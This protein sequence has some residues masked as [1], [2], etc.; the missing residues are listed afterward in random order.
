[1]RFIFEG[2]LPPYLMAKDLILT[3][4]GDVGFEGGTYRALQFTGSAVY[5]LS[6]EERMTLTN[7]AIEAGAKNGIIEA[8]DKTIDYVSERTDH[9][10]EPVFSDTDAR[11]ESER[12]YDVSTIEPVVAKPHRPDNRAN[13]SEVAGVRLDRAYIGS[14]TGGKLDDFRA[15]ARL[16]QGQEVRIDTYVVPSSTHVSEEM[17]VETMGGESLWDIFV[18]AG[19]KMGH[20]NCGA[21]LGGPLDTL[22]RT[23]GEEIVISTTNR[24]FPGRMG[25]RESSV[26]LASPLTAAASAISGVITDPREVLV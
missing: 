18:N 16:L 8:D 19:C 2:E 9:S 20:A 24:N 14:C 7:M 13:V 21:C 15:A 26:Y 1:M 10:F 11:Y 6:I 12:V 23:T 3:V 5:D 17:R 25:S 22:G 4:I